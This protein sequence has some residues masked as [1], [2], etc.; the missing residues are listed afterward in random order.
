MEGIKM[1]FGCRNG[2]AVSYLIAMAV[3][4]AAS[5]AITYGIMSSKGVEKEL[6]KKEIVEM[7]KTGNESDFAYNT[8]KG[9]AEANFPALMGTMARNY[10]QNR[11]GMAL[12][13]QACVGVVDMEKD[14]AKRLYAAFPVMSGSADPNNISLEQKMVEGKRTAIMHDEGAKLDYVVTQT[15]VM[16]KK[17]LGVYQ[18][19]GTAV[20]PTAQATK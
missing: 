6:A 18:V 14:Y 10:E 11:E 17:V 5:A 2:S 1:A 3:G 20:Q 19:P 13:V 7:V 4:A 16:G 9:A 15:D 12:T 8:F